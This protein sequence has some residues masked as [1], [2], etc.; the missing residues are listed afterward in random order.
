MV[1]FN[2]EVSQNL[3]EIAALLKA[4][5]ANHFRCQAYLNAAKTIEN[6]PDDLKKLFEVQGIQG[7]INLATIGVGIAHLI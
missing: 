5:H 3:R 4:Q 7:L 2:N 1:I 6:T